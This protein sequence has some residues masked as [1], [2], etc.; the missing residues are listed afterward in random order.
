MRQKF[1]NILIE[2]EELLS[3]SSSLP[4][5]LYVFLNVRDT[6]VSKNTS[7]P[8]HKNKEFLEQINTFSTK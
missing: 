4:L 1:F 8:I 2:F 6:F 7:S 3:E 5:P